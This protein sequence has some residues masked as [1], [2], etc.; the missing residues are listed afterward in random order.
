MINVE[1]CLHITERRKSMLYADIWRLE[2]I[3]ALYVS[4]NCSVSLFLN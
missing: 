4:Q 2:S 1:L 3:G